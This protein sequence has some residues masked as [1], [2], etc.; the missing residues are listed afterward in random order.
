M[1]AAT[2]GAPSGRSTRPLSV[3]VSAAAGTFGKGFCGDVALGGSSAP[4]VL[5]KRAPTPTATTAISTATACTPKPT[6]AVKPTI[7]RGLAP[8]TA[9][10]IDATG[11]A[12]PAV[13]CGAT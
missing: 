4:G 5:A 10:R 2:A 11:I 6:L 12:A 8:M 9:L 1:L 3:T 7:R 13:D